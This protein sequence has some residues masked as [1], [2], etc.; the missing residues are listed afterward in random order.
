MRSDQLVMPFRLV[1]ESCLFS[2]NTLLQ[3]NASHAR[4]SGTRFL[5]TCGLSCSLKL[6]KERRPHSWDVQ[7]LAWVHIHLCCCPPSPAFT[8]LSLSIHKLC[9]LYHSRGSHL[10]NSYSWK[11]LF[12][13]PSNVCYPRTI[14]KIFSSDRPCPCPPPRLHAPLR[15]TPPHRR[16]HGNRLSIRAQPLTRG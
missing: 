16:R 3:E 9:T 1:P 4:N 5:K 14:A 8:G 10:S 7:L 12:V 15:R 13:H 11:H 6:C 2:T